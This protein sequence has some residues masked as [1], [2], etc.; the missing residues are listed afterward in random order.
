MATGNFPVLHGSSDG[1]IA[2][3]VWAQ[4]QPLAT[5]PDEPAWR[6][7]WSIALNISTVT[8]TINHRSG[9]LCA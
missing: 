3:K 6:V 4:S 2:L 9:A 7:T 1:N 5:G 8:E